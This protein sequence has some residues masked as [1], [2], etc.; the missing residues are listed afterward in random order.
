MTP[1]GG[2]RAEERD[3]TANVGGHC[4]IVGHRRRTGIVNRF[5]Q[6]RN[7]EARIERGATRPLEIVASGDGTGFR[8]EPQP[9]RSAALR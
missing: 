4:S 8:I 7:M 9:V 3:G 2:N 5:N 6:E 1:V